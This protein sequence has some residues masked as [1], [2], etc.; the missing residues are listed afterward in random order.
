MSSVQ[1][2]N[3][4]ELNL[5]IKFYFRE[6]TEILG[7][8]FTHT[9]VYP[10]AFCIFIS[11]DIITKCLLWQGDMSRGNSEVHSVRNLQAQVSPRSTRF[12]TSNFSSQPCSRCSFPTLNV[13]FVKWRPDISVK[14]RHHLHHTFSQL[15]DPIGHVSSQQVPWLCNAC[16]RR[17]FSSRLCMLD[18]QTKWMS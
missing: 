17:W 7:T 8:W 5:L 2:E 12:R 13:H 4:T 10:S 11:C 6:G 3:K 14:W 18:F 16:S 15:H 9:C 1:S